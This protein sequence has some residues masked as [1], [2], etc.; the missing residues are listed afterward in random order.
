MRDALKHLVPAIKDGRLPPPSAKPWSGWESY[1]PADPILSAQRL[2][3]S[4]LDVYALGCSTVIV[5]FDDALE[6]AGR[7]EL[8]GPHERELAMEVGR[9]RA[10]REL[11]APLAHASWR[12]RLLYRMWILL[13]WL[14]RRGPALGVDEDYAIHDGRVSFRCPQCCQGMRL[15][16]GKRLRAS[17]PGCASAVACAT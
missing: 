7:V 15:P 2:A 12:T 3:R 16:L 10:Q 1:D 14:R 8:G 4:V 11:T 9:A 13:A 6:A 5:T 17:C